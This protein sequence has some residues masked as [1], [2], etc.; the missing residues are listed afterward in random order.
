[1]KR[2]LRTRLK[3]GWRAD[4]NRRCRRT[5]TAGPVWP[6][7]AKL[8]VGDFTVRSTTPER[9]EERLSLKARIV[10]ALPGVAAVGSGM[11]LVVHALVSGGAWP[12]AAGGTPLISLGSIPIFFAV[13][14]NHLVGPV[15]LGPLKFVL[16]PPPGDVS[17]AQPDEESATP[18]ERG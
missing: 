18:P 6:P 2:C 12:A 4:D 10:I 9:V 1:M 3:L 16:G 17:E 8:R 15:Q 11:S 7:A 14:I 5:T 13:L